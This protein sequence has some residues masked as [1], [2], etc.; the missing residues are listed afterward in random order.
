MT[1]VTIPNSV[2][3]ICGAFRDCTNLK[4]VV[5]PDSVEEI[6]RRAFEGCIGLT[7]VAI[8]NS[9]K[10][11]GGRA[12]NCCSGLT[13]VSIPNSV[14]KI[15]Y[16]AFA[17]CKRLTSIMIPN[18]VVEIGDFAFEYCTGLTSIVLSRKVK[19]GKNAF[20][21]CTSLQEILGTEV[22]IVD[23]AAESR[24]MALV[25]F[26]K[27]QELF[28]NAEIADGYRDYCCKK[29]AVALEAA[30]RSDCAKVLKDVFADKNMITVENFEEKFL[31]PAQDANAV[32]CVAYLL[33]WKNQNVSVEEEFKHIE[34]ELKK[35]PFNVADMKKLWKYSKNEDGTICINAYKGNETEVK[36]PERIGR[37]PVTA[38]EGISRERVF[39]NSVIITQIVIPNSVKKIAWHAFSDCIG[40]TSI[41]IP[42]SV[43]EIDDW[44]FEGCDLEKLVIHTPSGSYA[45]Q[46]AKEHGIK[47]ERT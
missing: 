2:K 34:R 41:V 25:G 32:Q 13:N 29:S 31:K 14:E 17:G 37:T 43:K 36:I 42:E 11:I 6:G 39:P 24:P 1:G 20:A 33:D 38:I 18:S 12:F 45:E 23:Y 21:S 15:G 8:P 28:T 27:H 19:L 40:L 47:F 16:N 22:P 26:L 10:E 44:A 9:V 5:I 46:Y 30:F 7:S 35:N 4:S 3:E